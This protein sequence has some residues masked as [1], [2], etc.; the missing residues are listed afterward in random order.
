[1]GREVRRVPKDWQ[2]PTNEY[3]HFVPLFDGSR[4]EPRTKEWDEEAAQWANGFVRSYK[5][6]VD[7]QPRTES[8]Y[9][10][11]YETYAEYAGERPDPADYMPA[12]AESER[13]HYMMYED[14]TEGT[15][16]SPAFETPEELARWLTDNEA[17]SFGGMTASYEAWLRVCKGAWAPGM[18][19]TQHPDGAATVQSGVEAL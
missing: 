18:V 15:P 1:M 3:G 4:L 10:T 6:G 8:E 17:S 11:K 19:V 2:H 12:W 13:T 9:A 16:I 14:T 5:E 7:W